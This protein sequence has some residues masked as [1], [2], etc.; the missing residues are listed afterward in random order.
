[1]MGDGRGL[2]LRIHEIMVFLKR[3]YSAM[4]IS[5]FSLLQIGHQDIE[6][7]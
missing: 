7:N 4:S 3:R 1:M 5:L 6:V 2:V